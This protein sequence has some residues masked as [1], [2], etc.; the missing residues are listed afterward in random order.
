QQ[1]KAYDD[2]FAA[3][4]ANLQAHG[5][6]KNNTLFVVTV[7][8]G[9]H[10]AGGVGVPQAGQSWLLYN[11][12]TCTNL[13]QCPTNQIGEVTTNLNAL[14]PAIDQNVTGNTKNDIHFDD[15][16]T[17][18]LTGQPGPTDPTVRR[19]ERDVAAL[20]SLDPYVRD[21]NGTVQSVQLAQFLADP[22]EEKTLHM[23]NSD[24]NRTPTFTMFGNPDFFFQLSNPCTG[25]AQCVSSGFAWNH[26]D[27]Q[28]EIG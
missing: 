12:T 20:T 18:Y 2:A 7:D 15:P 21:S 22:V 10:F 24:P 11:H 4:F 14:L 25:V 19:Y 27:V 5:I 17:F 28:Q 1:L 3:F 9:D 26:G 13:S 23:I 8:E 16:P 6:N